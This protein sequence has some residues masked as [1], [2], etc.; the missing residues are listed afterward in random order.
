[1][2]ARNWR[3]HRRQ[4]H[5][6]G[7]TTLADPKTQPP[8]TPRTDIAQIIKTGIFVSSSERSHDTVS[9]TAPIRNGEDEVIASINITGHDGLTNADSILE[10][11]PT[12]LQAARHISTQMF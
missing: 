2:A 1:M 11:Q 8:D 3:G 10:F 4:Y 7:P 5:R 9:L 6:F 12:V